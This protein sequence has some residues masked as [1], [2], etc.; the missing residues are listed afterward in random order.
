M[1]K[2]HNSCR[3]ARNEIVLTVT[4]ESGET[5]TVTYSFNSYLKVLYEAEE[6]YEDIAAAT[7]AYGLAVEAYQEAIAQ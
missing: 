5:A 4:N 7:Y 3:C 2:L 6:G 1:K